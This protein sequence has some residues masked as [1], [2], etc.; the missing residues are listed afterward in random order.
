MK[1]HIIQ[2]NAWVKPGEYLAWADRPVRRNHM[3]S[4]TEGETK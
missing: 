1:I 3:K 2:H 4:Y